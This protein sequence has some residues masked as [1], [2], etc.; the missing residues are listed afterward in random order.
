MR[1]RTIGAAL[2]AVLAILAGCM[3][4]THT[5]PGAGP[6]LYAQTVPATVK[7]QWDPNPTTDT[8]TEYRVTVDGGAPISVAPV[9]VAACS[10]VQTI[11]TIPTFGPH[12]VAVVAV[13]LLLSGDPTSTQ[14][15]PA[16]SLPFTLSP[17]PGAV[18]NGK[19]TK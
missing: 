11:L 16:A 3:I 14:L 19:I 5:T 6:V 1:I 2:L 8:I 13:N 18:K 12:T 9:T 17:P 15:S 10:C 7:A 4:A